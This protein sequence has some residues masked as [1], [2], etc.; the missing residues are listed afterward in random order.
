MTVESFAQIKFDGVYLLIPQAQVGTIE[1]SG[2]IDAEVSM[3]GAIGT[4]KSANN[5][6]PAFALNAEMQQHRERPAHYRFCLCL[7][8]ADEAVLAMACEEVLTVSLESS[9]DL[10]PIPACMRIPSCP[11]MH[12][13]LKE[14]QI[15]MVTDT[16]TMQ[17][18][19]M[20]EVTAV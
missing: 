15:M 9:T 6:W 20:P 3:E 18:Y 17:R 8:L 7:N 19:L 2:N 14:N 4:V 11:V 10:K 12:L 1:I 5:A 16:E 13:V